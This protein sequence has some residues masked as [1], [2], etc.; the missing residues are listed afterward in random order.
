MITTMITIITT[1]TIMI[2]RITIMI[3][4]IFTTVIATQISDYTC[5]SRYYYK[6]FCH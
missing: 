1:I 6:R 2:T 5:V 3:T 4:I